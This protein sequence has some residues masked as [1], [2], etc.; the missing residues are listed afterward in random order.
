MKWW[1]AGAGLTFDAARPKR[2]GP[3]PRDL[4]TAPSIG[5]RARGRRGPNA[6]RTQVEHMKVVA[7]TVVARGFW[8]RCSYLVPLAAAPSSRSGGSGHGH[9]APAATCPP[10]SHL[11]ASELP[12]GATAYE[13]RLRG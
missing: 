7:R 12:L 1:S 4:A 5:N 10:P 13:G 11:V 3:A 2:A 8:W 6:R 9:A